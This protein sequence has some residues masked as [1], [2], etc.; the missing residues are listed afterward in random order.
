[1][2]MKKEGWAYKKLQWQ[3]TRERE[4]EIEVKEG[5]EYGNKSSSEWVMETERK[6]SDN[7]QNEDGETDGLYSIDLG[8]LC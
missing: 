5:R 3:R 1:M 7:T 2:K 6:M 8:S 4:E